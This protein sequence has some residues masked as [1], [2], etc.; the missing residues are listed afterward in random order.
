[1]AVLDN[2]P[3]W[4]STNMIPGTTNAD[5]IYNEF[6][7]RLAAGSVTIKEERSAPP[8][9]PTDLDAYLIGSNPPASGEWLGLE[10][11]L[12]VWISGWKFLNP[13]TGHRVLVEDGTQQEQGRIMDFWLGNWSS[14]GGVTK[15]IVSE[16][17]P[18]VYEADWNLKY[19]QFGVLTLNQ[20][21][22]TL[23][24][25]VGVRYGRPMYLHVKQDG[26]GGRNLVLNAG[27]FFTE[28]G[29]NI[30]FSNTAA[31]VEYLIEMI[32]PG[33]AFAGPMVRSQIENLLAV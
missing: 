7:A 1:M 6:K 11:R 2:D 14:I 25:P 33:P 20:A 23:N 17:A 15:V 31:N 16:V 27:D 32:H 26:V 19:G 21:T 8:G 9:A 13:Q 30:S 18:A 28:G 22:I 29:A 12:T 3:L 24:A 10:G 4:Q 5:V